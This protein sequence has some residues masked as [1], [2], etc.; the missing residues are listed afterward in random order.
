MKL[1]DGYH[2]LSN[3]QEKPGIK[4]IDPERSQK[5]GLGQALALLTERMALRTLQTRLLERAISLVDR[6]N[7]WLGQLH[8]LHPVFFFN[9]FNGISLFHYDCFI[10]FWLVLLL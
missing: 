3:E 8:D 10:F 4:S 1:T 6:L 7:D 9:F 5:R 2:V